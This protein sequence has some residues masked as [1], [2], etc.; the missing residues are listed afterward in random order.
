MKIITADMPGSFKPNAGPVDKFVRRAIFTF[1][2]LE[3]D[4]TVHRLRAGLA[5]R[6]QH[7]K[8]KT[9]QGKPKANGRKTM[10]DKMPAISAIVLK[11]VRAAYE[12]RDKCEFGWRTL[13]TR[14][15]QILR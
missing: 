9:Q 5:R 3:R 7:T 14:L 2:E 12:S 10:L 11:K 4:L 15:T 1:T 8:Q 6:L 13:A